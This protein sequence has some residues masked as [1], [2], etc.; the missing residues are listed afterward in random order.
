MWEPRGRGGQSHSAQ[1]MNTKWRVI[2]TLGG[3]ATVARAKRSLCNVC[4]IPVLGCKSLKM[5]VSFVIMWMCPGRV[6]LFTFETRTLFRSEDEKEKMTALFLII[7]TNESSR[8]PFFQIVNEPQ[9]HRF[10]SKIVDVQIVSEPQNRRFS[11]K[12]EWIVSA[13]SEFSQIVWRWNVFS[14]CC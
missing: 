3:P 9:N 7:R 12:I 8:I 14:R 10:S 4:P 13:K 5:L 1:N 6:D 2:L 11:S